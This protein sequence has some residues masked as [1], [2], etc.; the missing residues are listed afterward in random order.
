M[1]DCVWHE[2]MATCPAC[3]DDVYG[4]QAA[5]AGPCMMRSQTA[6][7]HV[8][9]GSAPVT[10]RADAPASTHAM[11]RQRQLSTNLC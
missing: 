5:A 1:C 2:V 9:L 6:F 11:L 10:M 8:P 4:G 3:R 7:A